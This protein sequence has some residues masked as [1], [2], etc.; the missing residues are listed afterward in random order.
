MLHNSK[1]EGVFLLVQVEF[2]VLFSSLS[3]NL[4]YANTIKLK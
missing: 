4:P 1:P 3:H 2:G